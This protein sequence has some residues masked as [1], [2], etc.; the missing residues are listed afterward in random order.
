MI[1]GA[2]R[3]SDDAAGK[4]LFEHALAGVLFAGTMAHATNCGL[5][6]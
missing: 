4:N 1:P 6:A 3:H 5:R 2:D